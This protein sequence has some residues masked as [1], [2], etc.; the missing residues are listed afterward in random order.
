MQPQKDFVLNFE[1]DLIGA[2]ESESSPQISGSIETHRHER[3]RCCGPFRCIEGCVSNC[4]PPPGTGFPVI[5]LSDVGLTKS[6]TLTWAQP[7][8]VICLL[9]LPAEF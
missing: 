3:R 4:L 9:E 6:S 2:V 1:T 7:G 8:T 5:P